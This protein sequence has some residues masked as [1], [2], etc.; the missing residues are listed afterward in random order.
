MYGIDLQHMWVLN[1]FLI[2]SVYNASTKK[3]VI[4]ANW[5]NVRS[6]S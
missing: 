1:Q 5:G 4:K 3:I 6:F 2:A